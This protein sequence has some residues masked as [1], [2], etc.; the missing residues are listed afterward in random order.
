MPK[1]VC[2]TSHNRQLETLGSD[3]LRGPCYS[4][5]HAE[6]SI[7]IESGT[8]TSP[9]MYKRRIVSL[10]PLKS[11]GDDPGVVAQAPKIGLLASTSR[12]TLLNLVLS[13]NGRC[14][15][16]GFHHRHPID[17]YKKASMAL[18]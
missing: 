18:I 15:Q 7:T 10:P 3:Y 4:H 16:A 13:S 9:G 2:I 1:W 11:T 12:V 5:M 17:R 14:R 8:D 6:P